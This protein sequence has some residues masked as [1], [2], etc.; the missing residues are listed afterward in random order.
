[1]FNRRLILALLASAMYGQTPGDRFLAAIIRHAE[2]FQQKASLAVSEETLLQRSYTLPPHA[3]L[4]IG[5]AAGP[6]FARFFVHEIVSEYSIGSLR[7][8]KSGALLEIREIVAEDGHPSQTP[9]AARKALGRNI[10][11]GEEQI[12]KKILSE[13]TDLGLVD[14][15]TDYGL[16]L[17]AFTKSGVARM[18]I[19]PAGSAWIGTEEA[20]GVAWRQTDGGVLEFRGR[21]VARLPM[22]GLI[23]VRQSDG[24]PLR[25]SASTEHDEPKH[26][27][28]DDSAVDYVLARF[29][30]VMPASVVHR[31][32]VDDQLLTENLYTYAPFQLFTT[33]TNIRYAEP[34]SPQKK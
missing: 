2:L 1:M 16:M 33:D 32:F 20:V 30:C 22:H 19:T 23:W 5:P 26:V 21:K 34:S 6:L 12:R 10:S 14:V 27:L 4:A 24:T 8:D 28:R 15:A 11:S 13:F 31:H 18:E 29:G 9:Q 17:L 7:G 25:I 3:H